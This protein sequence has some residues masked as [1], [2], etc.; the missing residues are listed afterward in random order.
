[1]AL[2]CS[3]YNQEAVMYRMENEF[4]TLEMDENGILQE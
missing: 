4:I 3:R 2:Y 1:M